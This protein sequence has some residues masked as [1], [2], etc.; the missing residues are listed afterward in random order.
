MPLLARLLPRDQPVDLGDGG[1][2][3]ELVDRHGTFEERVHIE[4]AG[5]GALAQEL[6]DAFYPAHEL[7]EEPV[8][9]RVHFVHEFVEVVL[10]ARAEVD[11][12][13]DG[14]IGVCG[15]VLFAAF[16]DDLGC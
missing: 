1:I 6:E 15:N 10:V 14:L 9:V 13:L 3:V 12:G 4:L 5:G 16:F 2:F 11:E 8:V 7:C